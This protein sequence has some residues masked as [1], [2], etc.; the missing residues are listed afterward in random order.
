M[1]VQVRT[2]GRDWRA[3]HTAGRECFPKL[4]AELPV[5][6]VPQVAAPLQMPAIL[7]RR[8]AR[9]L[10]HPAG[11]GMLRDSAKPHAAAFQFYKE[12]NVVRHQSSPGQNFHGEEVRSGQYVHVRLNE[13]PPRRAAISL[14][15]WRD[16]VSVQDV[17]HRSIRDLMTQIHQRADDPVAC[18]TD[19]ERFDFR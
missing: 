4:A 1:G 11:I 6:I 15:C 7:H 9:H 14:G 19:H 8:V 5:A 10:L 13:L 2:S 18:E 16:V 12:Q 17:A 3:L